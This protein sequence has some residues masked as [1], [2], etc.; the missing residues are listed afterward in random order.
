MN[1]NVSLVVF[2]NVMTQL[3]SNLRAVCRCVRGKAVG[4][5]RTFLFTMVTLTVVTIMITIARNRHH[6]PVRCTGHMMKHG[7][8]NNRSAFLPLGIGRTN[9]VPVVFTSSILVFPMAVT[10]FVSGRFIR[11][12]TS[13]FA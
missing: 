9:M 6:V 12:T 7:V 13:L 1:G 3:P 5:F 8:C 10:R 11:G 2:T 4:V